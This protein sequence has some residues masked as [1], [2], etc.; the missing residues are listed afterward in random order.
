M[1]TIQV[2]KKPKVIEP[3]QFSWKRIDEG[4]RVPNDGFNYIYGL[5]DYE[6]TENQKPRQ[7]SGDYEQ[8]NKA[9][10]ET[11]P[12]HAMKPGDFSSVPDD[13]L[14]LYYAVLD[15]ASGYFLDKGNRFDY[16]SGVIG[17][18]AFMTANHR[19]KTD[20]NSAN[21]NG[22]RDPVAG[23]NLDSAKGNLRWK[24][25]TTAG[26]IFRLIDEAHPMFGKIYPTLT[27]HQKSKMWLVE[28]GNLSE[29]APE[30]YE[31][32]G[33]HHLVHWETEVR[34][35]YK[36]KPHLQVS[37]NFGALEVMLKKKGVAWGGTPG[38][39]A[40]AKGY[41]LVDKHRAKPIGAGE[42]IPLYV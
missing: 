32:V 19:Y 10:P 29:P 42:L 20:N 5:R 24:D 36:K 21:E 13:W 7:L 27:A 41:S 38:L 9:V 31:I 3:V 4:L 28:C 15:W 30:L 25:L 8:P 1:Q 37:S 22:Y 26:N 39:F 2:S 12:C 18:Y 14:W 34:V 35:D 33:Q 11:I 23:F 40:N 6:W 17:A 16:E